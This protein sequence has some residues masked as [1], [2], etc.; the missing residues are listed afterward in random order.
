MQQSK[1]VFNFENCEK[2]S[3]F[4]ID[5]YSLNNHPEEVDSKGA[6][7]GSLVNKARILV[8]WVSDHLK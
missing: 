8:K 7:A 2:S 4:L 5:H 3:R 6:F 1:I